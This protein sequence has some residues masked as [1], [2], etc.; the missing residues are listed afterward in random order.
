MYCTLL[1]SDF[2]R[3]F[4]DI[5][6]PSLTLKGHISLTFDSSGKLTFCKSHMKHLAFASDCGGDVFRWP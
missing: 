2:W 5:E 4:K 6:N 1:Y 3:D